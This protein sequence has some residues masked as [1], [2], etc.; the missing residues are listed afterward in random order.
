MAKRPD[1]PDS[2]LDESKIGENEYVTL[3]QCTVLVKNGIDLM[4]ADMLSSDPYCEVVVAGM[5]RTTKTVEKSLNPVWNE[6]Y[7]FYT[8]GPEGITFKLS[9]SDDV[10]KNDPM[11]DCKFDTKPLFSAPEASSAS[12][13]SYEGVLKLVNAKKG[14]IGIK[15]TCRTMTPVKTEKL[16][17]ICESQLTEAHGNLQNQIAIADSF[18]LQLAAANKEI[19]ITKGAL[20]VSTSETQGVRNDLADSKQAHASAVAEGD[21][22]KR[23]LAQ[24]QAQNDAVRRD[25][26]KNQA[27]HSDTVAE[28][29]GT[30]KTVAERDSKITFLEGKMG[31]I[32]NSV[33][34]KNK[35]LEGLQKKMYDLEHEEH[36]IVIDAD[37]KPFCVCF[38]Q[39]CSIM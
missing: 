35:E 28:L 24:A 31:E 34:V 38:G 15:V 10:G 33:G 22:F 29:E 14:S 1:N 17:A 18:K 39:K 23:Q 25:L 6:T 9:D 30:R 16:L 36:P 5:V 7:T 37:A 27:A 21:A 32:Q 12:G 13:A 26:E 19:A 20:A 3:Y 2:L 8:E 4:V 11:G